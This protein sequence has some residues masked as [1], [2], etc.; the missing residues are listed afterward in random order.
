MRLKHVQIRYFE[1]LLHITKRLTVSISKFEKVAPPL[2]IEMYLYHYYFDRVVTIH[3]FIVLCSARDCL[4]QTETDLSRFVMNVQQS[5]QKIVSCPTQQ[6]RLYS[7][8]FEALI[9]THGMAIY[10]QYNC[11]L[12]TFR[13][14]Y[15]KTQQIFVH[16]HL[17]WKKWCSL[18]DEITCKVGTHCSTTNLQAIIIIISTCIPSGSFPRPRIKVQT[19]QRNGSELTPCDIRTMKLA[20]IKIFC[21]TQ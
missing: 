17:I 19:V 14:W 20:I 5:V 6:I 16:N 9:S 8:Q 3:R 10:N 1:T 12:S 21:S 11:S 4:L 7:T 2:K 15:H 13:N 18:C